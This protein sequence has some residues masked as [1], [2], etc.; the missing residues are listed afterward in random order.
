MIR[1]TQSTLTIGQRPE[2]PKSIAATPTSAGSV[3]P[4]NLVHG[5]EMSAT[6]KVEGNAGD[7]GAGWSLGFFQA[8]WVETNWDYYRGQ[9]EADGSVFVQKGR[10][11]SRPRQACFD[12]DGV[13]ILPFAFVGQTF[14]ITGVPTPLPSDVAL[15]ASPAFPLTFQLGHLDFPNDS[16]DATRLNGVT[17]QTNFLQAAQREFAFCTAFVAL[18]PS[19]SIQFLKAVYW[20]V[21]WQATFALNATASLL[22]PRV[23][24]AGTTANVGHVIQ[25]RPDDH[26]FI[27]VL[28]TAQTINCNLIA[29]NAA[30]AISAPASPN[31]REAAG[32]PPIDVRR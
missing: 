18:S 25:G 32:W 19:N 30:N 8:Q 13:T 1:F 14:N 22:T 11:P 10:A 2:V 5:I 28:T 12:C 24:P 26:R 16:A 17:G 29:Q 7:S 9:T 23:L 6:V 3:V 31:V 27:S 4:F 21:N 15:P 20:N